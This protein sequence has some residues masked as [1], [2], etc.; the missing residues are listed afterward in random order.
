MEGRRVKEK[1]KGGTAGQAGRFGRT[2]TK[3]Y[4]KEKKKE[5][6]SVM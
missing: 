2:E 4:R 1:G 6:D 3:S 5:T